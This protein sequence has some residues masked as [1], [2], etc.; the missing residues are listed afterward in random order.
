MSRP[1]RGLA[2]DLE[3]DGYKALARA[4]AEVLGKV[5]AA[6]AREMREGVREGG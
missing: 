2:C 3:S 4:T 1:T 6:R 5:G